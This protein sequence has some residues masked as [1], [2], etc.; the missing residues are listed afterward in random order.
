[1]WGAVAATAIVLRG[2]Q[3]LRMVEGK[4]GRDLELLPCSSREALSTGI[5]ITCYCMAYLPTPPPPPSLAFILGCMLQSPTDSPWTPSPEIL[6]E[7][8]WD[9]AWNESGEN[10]PGDSEGQPAQKTTAL[11]VSQLFFSIWNCMFLSH[12][13]VIYVTF[14]P[15]P[16]LWAPRWPSKQCMCPFT[17]PGDSRC[18]SLREVAESCLTWNLGSIVHAYGIK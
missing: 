3:W 9:P 14:F 13:V 18:P 10:S 1:M 17:A 8:V 5:L 12:T 4:D 2:W 15:P 6:T 7:L 16:R 11:T